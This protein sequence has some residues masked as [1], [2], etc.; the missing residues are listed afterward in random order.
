[1]ENNYFLVL[2]LLLTFNLV[3][4]QEKNEEE[5]KSKFQIIGQSGI[6]FA[7]IKSDNQP[8][9]NLNSIAGEILLNYKFSDKSGIA[10]G[11][12]HN[13][14][15]GNGFNVVGNFYHERTF[16]KIPLIYT[17][18]YKLAKK[19]KYL[20][21]IGLYAQ[22]IVRDEYQFL[23]NTEKNIYGGWNYGLE[24]TISLV[25][26]IYDKFGAGINFS[27]QSDFTKLKTNQN[28]I[29]NDQQRVKNQNSVGI[30]LLFNF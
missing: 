29:I 20:S 26:Q 27:G 15:T 24:A 9:Y 13:E 23:N 5:K 14:L 25:Y 18:E 28:Q 10:I 21:N 3:Q 2:V 1:M 4:G 16:I 7:A 12:G 19:L 17:T 30:I 6:G 11:F 22:T 8:T